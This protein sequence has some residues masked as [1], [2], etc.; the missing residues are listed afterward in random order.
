MIKRGDRV[1]KVSGY[2]WPGIVVVKFRTTKGELRF[3]VEC[4]ASACKGALHIYNEQQLKVKH[5]HS[6]ALVTKRPSRTR[7]LSKIVPRATSSAKRAGDPK[8]VQ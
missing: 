5:E 8:R 2:R 4:T 6:R 1:V 3:V 7:E